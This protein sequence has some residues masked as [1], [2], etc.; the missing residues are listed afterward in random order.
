[1]VLFCADIGSLLSDESS[2]EIITKR[3]KEKQQLIA[4]VLDTLTNLFP[5]SNYFKSSVDTGMGFVIGNNMLI[6]LV[7]INV[8]IYYIVN[9]D[10]I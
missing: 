8:F 9:L 4:S 1:M 10:F 2:L 3:S 6:I 5:S 7:Y